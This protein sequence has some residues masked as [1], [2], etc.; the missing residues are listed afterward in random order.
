MGDVID[1]YPSSINEGIAA[2]IVLF[3]PDFGGIYARYRTAKR[4][5]IL[6][7]E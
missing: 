6:Q 7:L 1:K 4:F 3:N 2:D 5:Q